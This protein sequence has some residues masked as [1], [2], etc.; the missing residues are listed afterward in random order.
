MPSTS[1]ST[2]TTDANGPDDR[3]DRPR[4]RDRARRRLRR[5]QAEPRPRARSGAPGERAGRA[6]LD[7]TIVVNTGDDLE[8]HGLAV[9]PD[10]DTVMYTLAGP[11]QRRDRLGA[12]RR[13]LVGGRD[14]RALRRSRPG[15][16]S[17]DRDLG[18]PHP[19]DRAR[20][21]S[22]ARLTEVT[23]RPRDEPRASAPRLLPMSRRPG[24]DRGPDRRTA[25]STSRTTSCGA[26]SATASSRSRATA[27]SG[28]RPTPEVLDAIA[29]RDAHRPRAL[30]PVRLDRARSSPCRARST[31]SWRRRPRSWRS[32]RSSAAR[33]CAGRPTGCSSRSAGRRRRA[34]SS[35]HYADRTRVSLD[36]AVVDVARR[37][38]HR[39]TRRSRA[40]RSRS[41]TRSCATRRRPRAPRRASSS[42]ASSDLRPS[43]MP[44]TGDRPPV[45]TLEPLHVVLPL[46]TLSGGKARLGGALDAEEREALILGHARRTL[47]V[48]LAWPGCAAHPSRQP[49][50]DAPGGR[51][52]R[53]GRRRQHA[54]RSPR[55][56]RPGRARASAPAIV[57]GRAG[58][59]G[60]RRQP[61][62]PARRPARALARLLDQLL[63]AAD[64]AL[65]AGDGRAAR[66]D[67][68]RRT[69]VAART[70]CCC[71][72]PT[73]SSRRSAS[74]SFEAHLRAAAAA[75]AARPGRRRRGSASTSTRPRTSSASTRTGSASS[76]GS[77]RSAE[78]PAGG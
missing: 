17:G 35:R 56:R 42:T 53:V 23:A 7:L 72:R 66:G 18:D 64:A 14:A 24:P 11:R 28:A 74:A 4:D 9:S 31:R 1:P 69:P 10:L 71:A 50:P 39:R 70:R 8:L 16:G 43:R 67:R 20:C 37:R 19:A 75:E 76:C 27:S 61:A 51:A 12:P 59:S 6:P 73:S 60:R 46:R 3:M 34:G 49:G 22:G 29:E 47:G 57:A 13:D 65:A 63:D 45:R 54:R 44:A 55:Q 25:G 30:Q 48:L 40:S 36:V 38:P 2:R 52:P 33:R 62:R 78:E 26:G 15:S 32:A 68:A 5:R 41:R 77:G 21:A 58:R